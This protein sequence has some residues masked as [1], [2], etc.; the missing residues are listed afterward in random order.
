[1]TDTSLVILR[2][3]GTSL[4]EYIPTESIQHD[5]PSIFSTR[6]SFWYSRNTHAIS[7]LPLAQAWIGDGDHHWI[8]DLRSYSYKFI[9]HVYKKRASGVKSLVDSR[10]EIHR[11][12]VQ[13]LAPLE[14]D[15]RGIVV[16]MLDGDTTTI[17]A[18]LPRH[19]LG[20]AVHQNELQ[21][22][23][24]PGYIVDVN[25]AGIGCLVGLKSIL[26]LR[27]SDLRQPRRKV[28]VPKGSMVIAP[29]QYGHVDISIDIGTSKGYFVYDVDDVVGR[30]VG[31]RTMESDLYLAKLHA[32]TASSQ[33][34]LLTQRTGT[35]EA[36]DR[37]AS[38]ASF[39]FYTVSKESRS[40]LDDIATLT[41]LRTFYPVHLRVM[42]TVNWTN[43]PSRK[44]A[45]PEFRSKVGRYPSALARDGDFPPLGDLAKILNLCQGNGTPHLPRGA[46]RLDSLMF[47]CAQR[48]SSRSGLHRKRLL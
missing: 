2:R 37:V 47:D 19:D 34:D 30:L 36:L 43:H 21:C 26:N 7:I 8:L 42:E 5:L 24:V 17:S 22:L 25:L 38:A 12:L 35:D 15:P 9:G 1:M 13:A 18:H 23:S 10:S 44:R 28:I 31:T 46:Q 14:P 20:F 27:H 33:P 41:P 4:Q 39:S 6:H 45:T 11:S 40:Y 48:P 32:F 29:G 3:K 16:T